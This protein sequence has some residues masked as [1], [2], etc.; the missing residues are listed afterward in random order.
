VRN[1]LLWQLMV[2]C[3]IAWLAEQIKGS[4]QNA[5]DATH[6]ILVHHN[7]L[8]IRFRFDEK[9]FD[10]DGAYDVEHEI[11]RSRVD[12]ATIKGDKQRLTQPG[13][14]AIVYSRPEEEEEMLAYITFLRNKEF[15]CDGVE[16]LEL[17]DLPGV[18]G[19]RALRVEVKLD[20]PAIEARVKQVMGGS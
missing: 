16:R 8:S 1:L 11:I 20:S 15:L 17:D 5:F 14:I 7:P 4:L 9:R 2:A 10:V 18:Q 13:N 3:G 19:L 12:K 6:L